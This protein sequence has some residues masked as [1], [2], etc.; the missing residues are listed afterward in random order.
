M[1]YAQVSIPGDGSTTLVPVEFALGAISPSMVRCYVTGELDG[2]GG[3]IYRTFTFT[4]STMV[5]VDGAPAPIGQFYIFERIVPK[6][7]LIVDWTDGDPITGENLDKMQKQALHMTHEALDLGD[8]AIKAPVG[9]AGRDFLASTPD[10]TLIIDPVTG[11]IVSGPTSDEISNAQQ[12][13]LDAAASAAAAADIVDEAISAATI[14][15]TAAGT[16]AGQAAANAAV[17]VHVADLDNPH[18]VTKAQVGLGSVDNVS[19]ASLRDRTTHTGEQAISTVTGLQSALDGKAP[20]A[21]VTDTANPHGVTK[22]QVGLGNADNTS[23][24]DKPVSTAQATALAAKQSTSEKAQPNGYAS[25]GSDGKVPSSQLPVSGSYKGTWNAAT[26]TPTITSGVGVNGDFYKVAVAGSTNIDGTS[27]WTVG[28]EVRFNGTIWQRI[29]SSSAVS[30]VNGQ[31]GAVV[32]AKADLGLGNVDNTSDVNKPISNATQ[33]A[34]DGKASVASINAKVSK[35]G[36][37]MTGELQTPYPICYGPAGTE[38][39]YRVRTN[40]TDRWH[41]GANATAETGGAEGSDF[42][43]SRWADDGVTWLGNPIEIDRSSGVV[44]TTTQLNANSG[45]LSGGN[46]AVGANFASYRWGT[47][48][49]S[50]RAIKDSNNGVA[51]NIVWQHSS[52]NFVTNF[53]DAMKMHA[54]G[55]ME[56]SFSPSTTNPAFRVNR[57]SFTESLGGHKWYRCIDISNTN[58]DNLFT[59]GR[60]AGSDLTG[61]RPFTSTDWWYIFVDRWDDS[62]VIQ[63]AH[64]MWAGGLA[65][66]TA[67]VWKRSRMGSVW[68]PWLPVSGFVTP[69][70]FGAFNGKGNPAGA[71]GSD[72]TAI[73]RW[74]DS[75]SPKLLDQWY[76]LDNVLISRDFN[77][78][79]NNGAQIFGTGARSGL[80][81]DNNSGLLM[82]GFDHDNPTGVNTDTVTLKDF[83]MMINSYQARK[84]LDIAFSDGDSGSSMPGLHMSNVHIVPTN[85]SNGV[86]DSIV[87]LYNVRNAQISDCSVFGRYGTYTGIGFSLGGGANSASVEVYFNNC[88]TNHVQKGWQ[89][90]AS[91]GA[92]ANDDMQGIHWEKCTAIA[93]DRGWDLNS[94]DGFSEWFHLNAC[95]AYFRELGVYGS[96]VGNVRS[97][98]GYYLGH[99]N[100]GTCQGIAITGTSI[101]PWNALTYNRIRLDAATGATRIGINAN[102]QTGIAQGNRVSGHTSNYV[103]GGG[104]TNVN[105]T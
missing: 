42:Y 44:T 49:N 33:A 26:N 70:H 54:G 40:G 105:N 102:A 55:N 99:G 11:D 84:P 50:W 81:L 1:S 69:M 30:S 24:A 38:R 58:I 20:I 60:Y 57:D 73:Q 101:E 97:D 82:Y 86:S 9:A 41:I 61:T 89:V 28:D 90:A 56:F 5:Q 21:H 43:I 18:E 71:M 53:I 98:H 29:V 104:W 37:T 36:D 85:T 88:R 74:L 79:A 94:A 78:T 52:D 22:A 2:G 13:A 27:T 96:N 47:G 64:L 16:V 32:L 95:H 3:Q 48:N 65:G 51:G 39:V 92:T 75:D 23:D 35:A 34:L 31:T 62:L 12:Y 66:S 68:G 19:A 100:L 77:G 10:A 8:R 17:S 46:I 7:E 15:G 87:A 59:A 80:R 63:E 76:M 93:V 45:I 14:A 25:L 4:T 83:Q 67:A 6:D 72:N 103:F 91:G